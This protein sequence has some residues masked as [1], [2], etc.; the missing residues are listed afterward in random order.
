MAAKNT[1]EG[2]DD[3]YDL[4]RFVSAQVEDYEQAL[5]EIT[6]GRKTSHWMWYIFP[7]FDGLGMSSMSRRY[8][9]KSLDEAKA[10]LAHPVL[11]PRLIKCVEA[12]LGVEGRSAHDIFG[13]P[14]DM[15]L[16]SSATLFE[17]VS[18]KGSIFEQL[19]D[20]YYQG[21]RDQQTLTLA[22]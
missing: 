20:R 12:A 2:A 8:S 19:L 21:G 17:L 15:K 1:H 18:P 22:K 11:G 16:K 6:R 9:I 14:D 10:Y 4:G 3:P 5:D 7:Q 13:S